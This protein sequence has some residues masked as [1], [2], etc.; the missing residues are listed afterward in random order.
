MNY[1]LLAI[2]MDNSLFGLKHILLVVASAII[3]V[4]G[5]LFTRKVS[6]MN[7]AK[8]MLYVGVVSEIIK[9]FYYIIANEEKF[10]GVLPKTDLP[11]HLCSVQIIFLLIINISKNEA[12]RRQLFSFMMPSCLFGGIAAILIATDSSRSTWIITLQYFLYHSAITVFA[13]KLLLS[14]EMEWKVKDL[15][16]CFKLLLVIMFFAIYI[17]SIVYDGQSNINFMYVVG[18]PQEGLPYLNKDKG[19][20]VYIIRYAVLVLFCVTICYIKPIINAIK[21]KI[22]QKNQTEGAE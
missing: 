7:L 8:I 19:W 2:A 20:L 18:P 15:L 10:G 16:G 21:E 13:L 22:A 17:N 6:V 3:I 11:F 14:K 9:I 1:A 5:Y 4:L 12:F